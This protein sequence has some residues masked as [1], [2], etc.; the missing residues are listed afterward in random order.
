[1]DEFAPALGF[2]YISNFGGLLIFVIFKAVE[3]CKRI[4]F[5]CSS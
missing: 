3:D 4:N 1:M 5:N 2:K